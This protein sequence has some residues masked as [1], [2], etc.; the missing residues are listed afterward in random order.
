MTE[1]CKHVGTCG[2]C[3]LQDIPDEQVAKKKENMVRAA[4][5]HCGLD[6]PIRTIHSSPPYSRRRAV[7]SGRRT[8]K[9]T[10]LGFFA[11]RSEQLVN[12]EECQVVMPEIVRAFPAL[13]RLVRLSATRQSVV[14]ISVTVSDSGLDVAIED[15][16]SLNLNQFQDVITCSKGFARLT[17][18][19]EMVVQNKPPGHRFGRAVVVP[20]PGGFMQATVDG[21]AA[22]TRAVR[23]ATAGARRVLD[24]FAGAGTFSLPVSEQADVHAVEGHLAA[25]EALDAA[26]RAA[27]GG[28]TITT[29]ARDLFKRPLLPDELARFDAIIL[30]P[31]RAGASAQVSEIAKA[32]VPK[33]AYVSCNPA[34]F[35]KD[36]ALLNEAG[37]HIDFI[38]VIDQFRWSNHVELASGISFRG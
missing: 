27:S 5:V 2:G 13:H 12:L 19:G 33:L 25:L 14:R 7:L 36:A 15:A 29:E 6:A 21:Q 30:D 16:K 22:L 37:Y 18:N 20:P 35:A 26:W 28:R 31:P 4:L 11:R 34:S 38:D 8:K 3:V 23:E 24:L 9:T 17:W 1:L 32:R 10:Q